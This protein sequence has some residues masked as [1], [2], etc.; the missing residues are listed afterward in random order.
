MKKRR[1]ELLLASALLLL[2]APA[3]SAEDIEIARLATQVCANCHGPHGDSVSSAFPR[4]AGQQAAYIE[5]QL[6]AF[7]DQMLLLHQP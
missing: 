7:K 3:F 2:V 4:L 6:E 5:V 1:Q